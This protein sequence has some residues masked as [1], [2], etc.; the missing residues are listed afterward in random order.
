MASS[1]KKIARPP[2]VKKPTGTLK[3]AFT[4][5]IAT[6]VFV[7][8][9]SVFGEFAGILEKNGVPPIVAG[10]GVLVAAL[11]SLDTFNNTVLGEGV[12]NNPSNTLAFAAAGKDVFSK[13]TVRI[14][15]QVA[16]GVLG[17]AAAIKY[18]PKPWLRNLGELAEGVKPGV[19]LAAGAFCEFALAL[20]LNLAI[21]YSMSTKRKLVGALAPLVITVVLV[22]AGAGFTGPSMNPAHAFSWNYFLDGHDRAQ[23]I[24]VFWVAPLSGAMAAGLLWHAATSPAAKLKKRKAPAKAPAKAAG[25]ETK[26]A[27]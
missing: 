11:I 25:K 4:D 9:S 12:L 16:G 6:A 2:P 18:I 22:V 20:V 24:A 15:A 3:S 8:A 7:F 14:G 27:Q 5:A 10:L 26:K 19:S 13:A 1:G 17:A 21:L 23:H